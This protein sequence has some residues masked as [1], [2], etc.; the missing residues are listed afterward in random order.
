M[1]EIVP[2]FLG[3]KQAIVGVFKQT[4]PARRFGN[5]LRRI[6]TFL[7]FIVAEFDTERKAYVF[8]AVFFDNVLDLKC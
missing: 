7:K 5:V 4:D 3:Q 8:R 2:N 1:V 6:G